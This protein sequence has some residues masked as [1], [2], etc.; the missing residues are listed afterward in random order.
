MKETLEITP[1]GKFIPTTRE[2]G[3]KE[4][5]GTFLTLFSESSFKS[6][7]DVSTNAATA[8][9]LSQKDKIVKR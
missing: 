6:F 4:E 2:R 3:S 7:P 9:S 5:G 1:K 8:S